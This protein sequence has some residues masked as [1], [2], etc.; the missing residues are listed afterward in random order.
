MPGFGRFQLGDFYLSFFY[1]MYSRVQ[2][3]NNNDLVCLAPL[4]LNIS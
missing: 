2:T 4:V 3:D 1:F